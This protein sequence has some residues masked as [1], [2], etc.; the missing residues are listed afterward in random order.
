MSNSNEITAEATADALDKAEEMQRESTRRLAV[1]MAAPALRRIEKLS[2]G[3][4]LPGSGITER[5]SASV[6]LKAN[7]AILAQAHGRPETRDGRGAQVEA[8]LTIVVNQ[9]STGQERV[10]SGDADI[11]RAVRGAGDALAIANRIHSEAKEK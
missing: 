4:Q 2:K 3:H 6:Q 10:V 1:D 11:R 9:L 5:P 7:E 8:G